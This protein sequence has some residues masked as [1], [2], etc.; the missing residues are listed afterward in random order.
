MAET[1]GHK[2]VSADGHVQ[3]PANLWVE[4][5][6]RR[7]RDRA[8]RIVTKTY[9]YGK[10]EQFDAFQIE[11]L[12]SVDFIDTIATM[13]NEKAAGVPIE[14]HG[15]N[16]IAD[17]RAGAGDPIARL[18]DQDLDNV[19]AEV[20]YPN[21]GMYILAA[22]DVEYRRE[23]IRV[24]NDFL[25]EFCSAAPRRLVGVG[26]LPIGGPIQW[27][28]DEARRIARINLK[29]VLLPADTPNRP[30]WDN[31]YKPLWEALSDLGLPLA[32]HN[33]ATEQFLSPTEEAAGL[34]L[35]VRVGNYGIVETKIGNQIRS[36]TCLLGSAVPQ[37]YPNLQ[38]V[39]AEGGIGWVA[40]VIRLMD[41]WWE[42]H[43][44]YMEPKLDRTAQLLLPSP[45]LVHF[46]RRS[47]R[48][49]DP[50]I[51]QYRPPHVGE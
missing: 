46:R 3:E 51:A 42:D 8:P 10:H 5:M 4:R 31:Y 48:I 16:R 35:A 21:C 49:A 17:V 30:W 22:P 29:S 12:K 25:A 23:C 34:S 13:A 38:F 47:G 40:P 19:R 43:H 32:F 28:I 41:H 7:F 6:D 20:I 27:A 44:H 18:A 45:V 50:R 11:G 26:I 1:N 37:Q 33:T 2:F 9:S 14:G 24:Y 15:H 36:L 39:I